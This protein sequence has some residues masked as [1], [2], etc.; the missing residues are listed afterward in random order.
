MAPILE[1]ARALLEDPSRGIPSE[2]GNHSV[3]ILALSGSPAG[4]TRTTS[5]ILLRASVRLGQ[6]IGG[7]NLVLLSLVD[8]R[9][10]LA[11]PEEAVTDPERGY[12][13]GP[14]TRVKQCG[15][16]SRTVFGL[17]GMQVDGVSYR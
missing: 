13:Q 3:Q 12:L 14:E 16:G 6:G 17:S 7:P 4:P 5:P 1:P 10:C 2:T 8:H 15:H 9:G 11:V